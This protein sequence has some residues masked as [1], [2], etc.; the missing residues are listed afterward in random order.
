MTSKGQAQ[1]REPCSWNDLPLEVKQQIVE[2]IIPDERWGSTDPQKSGDRRLMVLTEISYNFGQDICLLPLENAARR[3][4]AI[5][6]HEHAHIVEVYDTAAKMRQSWA[7]LFKSPSLWP[8]IEQ[9]AVY[10]KPLKR[11][12]DQ[13]VSNKEK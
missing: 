13:A 7:A 12:N 1:A 3:S 10:S 9:L 11:L 4:L 5:R 8:P 2:Y 6:K